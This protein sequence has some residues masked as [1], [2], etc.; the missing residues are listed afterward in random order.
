MCRWGV[1]VKSCTEKAS[2]FEA[3]SLVRGLTPEQA[4]T[5]LWETRTYSH[6]SCARSRGKAS[7]CQPRPTRADASKSSDNLDEASVIAQGPLPSTNQCSSHEVSPPHTTSYLTNTLSE[8]N[9]V[10]TTM[11]VAESSAENTK[12]PPSH[13]RSSP[14]AWRNGSRNPRGPRLQPDR[15]RSL[16]W[17][18]ERGMR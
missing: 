16:A 13:V 15:V 12:T 10:S 6:L 4:R 9:V 1:S 3:S 5:C 11:Y 17:L 8:T 18:S 14:S 2:S 7:V